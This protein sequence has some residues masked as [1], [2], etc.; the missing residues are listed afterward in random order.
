MNGVNLAEL[1]EPAKGLNAKL[2]LAVLAGT[3]CVP[4]INDSCGDHDSSDWN[5][6]PTLRHRALASWLGISMVR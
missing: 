3:G 5:D 2:R 1:F 4:N 6:A